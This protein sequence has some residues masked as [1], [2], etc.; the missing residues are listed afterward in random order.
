MGSSSSPATNRKGQTMHRKRL[1][2]RD[3]ES[4]ARRRARERCGL[5]GSRSD[6]DSAIDS[7]VDSIRCGDAECIEKQSNRLSLYKVV[8]AG[9]H[10]FAVYDQS[11][12]MIVTFLTGLMVDE[13]SI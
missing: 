5:E 4:H 7:M 13:R 8:H 12:K 9:M 6:I 3:I 1:K 2:A 11:R 10:Y